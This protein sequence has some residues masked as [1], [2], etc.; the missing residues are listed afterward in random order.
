MSVVATYGKWFLYVMPGMATVVAILALITSLALIFDSS[1]RTVGLILGPLSLLASIGFL[2]GGILA[3]NGAKGGKLY[4]RHM[5]D[6]LRVLPM[7]VALGVALAAMAFFALRGIF[8]GEA[9]IGR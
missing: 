8:S 7:L 6:P 1:T 3:Y 2:R 5:F 4:Q 9:P